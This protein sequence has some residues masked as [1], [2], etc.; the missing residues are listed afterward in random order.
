MNIWISGTLNEVK[1]G[2]E[3]KLV[4]AVV[5]NPTVI[6]DW[7]KNGRSLEYVSKEVIDATG[8]PLY[9]QLIGPTTSAF[10]KEAEHLKNISSMILPK[11]P[12]TLAGLSAAKQ[13]EADGFETLVT[14]VVSINQAYACA[15]AGVTTICPYLNRLQE[16]GE[17]A[18]QFIRNVAQ[19]FKKQE[20]HTKIM[21]ASV[22]TISEIENALINGC[23]GVII[24]Y[25]LFVKMFEHK[26]TARSLADFEI[27]WKKIP[28]QFRDELDA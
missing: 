13:L 20:V 27:D 11:L 7:T 4:N 22:R 2:A 23:N 28:Y 25:P 8:L 3:T 14:T 21:P 9:V 16:S 1:Q 6:A 26:V 17:D 5:T 19:I 12:S 24:F 15:A 18:L 10:L